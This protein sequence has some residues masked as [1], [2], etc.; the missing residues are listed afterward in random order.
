VVLALSVV[1]AS[2]LFCIRSHHDSEQAVI[3]ILGAVIERGVSGRGQRVD[4]SLTEAAMALVVPSLASALACPS[5]TRGQGML[6][7]ALPNYRSYQTKDGR[8]LSVGALE[9]HFWRQ[10]CATAERPDLADL[11]T[12]NA[13]AVAEALFRSKTL[14]EWQAVFAKADVCVEPVID[15]DAVA[16]HPQ[17]VA[18]RVVLYS[19]DSDGSDDIQYPRK[20]LVLGPRLSNHPAIMLPPAPLIGE[21]TAAVLRS[22]GYAQAQIDEWHEKEKEKE[23]V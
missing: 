3:G 19:N 23:K 14:V 8:F 1:F 4:I 2:S 20:Q 5:P 22:A 21:H 16:R 12:V 17:H 11:A 6:D 9:P 10:L 18:R 15:A 13:M 7:G